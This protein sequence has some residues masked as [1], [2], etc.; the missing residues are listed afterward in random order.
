M[1][2]IGLKIRQAAP[3]ID[4]IV[5]DYA[6][7]YINHVEHSTT[8][9]VLSQ[10]LDIDQEISFI[11]DLLKNAG[12]D[13]L[14]I[15]KLADELNIKLSEELKQ[16]QSKLELTGDTSKRLLDINLLKNH[17]NKRNINSSLALLGVTKDIEHNGRHIE[18]KVDKKKLE[19]AEKK[20]AAKV[21]KRNNQFVKYEA[22]KLIN[23]SESQED[24]DQFFLKI[25][26]I[27]FGSGAGKSKDI[28]IDTFDLYVGDGQRILADAQLTLSYGHRYGLVGQNGI[29]KST[30]LKALSRRE[31]NVPKHITILHVEQEITGSEI[32]ALQSVLDADVWRKQ[33]L[34][35]EKKHNERIAEIE[36]LRKEFDE[37]SLE[38]KKLDN[39]R[40]DLELH[41]QEIAEKLYEMESDK[42]ESRAAS[43]LYGLGFTKESQQNPTNSFSG[44][45]RMRLSLA[46]ALFCKPDLLLLDEPSNNLD[47]PSITYLA[48]YLQTYE[49]TVLVVSHDRSFLNEVA[50]DIIHQHSERLDY[51]RGADFDNFYSTR[52]ERRKNELR[53][54]ENQ[55]AYRQHLQTFIDKFRYNAAKSS[56]AQSRIKKLEKLPVLEPPE[57]EKQITFK[58]PDPDGISPPIVTM[59]D[60]SFGYNPNDLLLKNVD[61]DI[62]LDSRIAL[63]GA[64]GCGKSTLLKIIMERIQPLD[65][66]VSKNPRLR[67]AYF[68]QHH[69]DSMDLT[70][71]AVDWL[72]KTF[73]GKTDEEYRRHLGSFGITGTLGLQR[74]QLLSGGQKSRVAFASL[75]LNNPHIL[76]L[77]E[78]SNHL[79]TS[80]LD[81]LADALKNFKGGVLM[82]SH[83]VSVINQV[84]NEIWVSERGSVKKF[85]G[86]IYDY[87]KYILAAAD[88]S[89][90]VK[91]H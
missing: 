78:P 34:S 13:D 30:L 64:N 15:S 71:S 28:H 26:P 37:D 58:F 52:E 48:N 27:E 54:Y 5:A 39:E 6:V 60:V 9:S 14:K 82:V 10:Q 90:V 7:G 76:I 85:N 24:Y 80:G 88:A 18:S 91:K 3:S 1:S 40:D 84:C 89:G 61:L 45:W 42:A 67:I 81:A 86:T 56:E 16:N 29:G 72:S 17:A 32:T 12:G 79:D 38:V 51:Y 8:D 49:S 21:A 74:M 35:E 53:E 36:T 22:S 59:K 75:C 63:V 2:N 66:H 25:N 69:V 4:P 77:D 31:L 19:K 73:P 68:A 65:G 23:E 41:L 57:Q 33:L 47:V 87:K 70:T 50:T 62:Q 11:S 55:M 43:I 83:D 46:R 20:I 44:G